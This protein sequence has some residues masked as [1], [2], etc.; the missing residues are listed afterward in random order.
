MKLRKNHEIRNSYTKSTQPVSP[1]GA[2]QRKST[3]LVIRMQYDTH[4]PFRK[5]NLC[6]EMRIEIKN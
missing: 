3:R 2:I 1:G 5:T 6:L 4:F